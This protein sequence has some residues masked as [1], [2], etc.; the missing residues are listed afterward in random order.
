M[1]KKAEVEPSHDEVRSRLRDA[2]NQL[3]ISSR[4]VGYMRRMV[5]T[6]WSSANRVTQ[7]LSQDPAARRDIG[8]RSEQCSDKQREHS[9]TNDAEICGDLKI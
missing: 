6:F 5:D 4:M 1:T 3:G 2:A 8:E 9:K 7:S